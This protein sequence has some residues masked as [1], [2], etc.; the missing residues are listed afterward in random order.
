MTSLVSQT[1][2]P[3]RF[4]ALDLSRE[5]MRFWRL[6]G[7]AHAGDIFTL[8][9]PLRG[10]GRVVHAL[11]EAIRIESR[12]PVEEVAV[13]FRYLAP[14]DQRGLDAYLSARA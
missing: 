5:G 7:E 4:Y 10:T 3:G 11:A 13:R 8:A 14:E 6:S 12:G 2:G 9:V 1:D